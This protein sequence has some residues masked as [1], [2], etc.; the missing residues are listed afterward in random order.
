MIKF[1]TSVIGNRIEKVEVVGETECFVKLINGRKDAKRSEWQNYFNSFDEAKNY[2]ID[3]A[4]KR[5][6]SLRTQLES[7]NGA[8][9]QIK[10]IKES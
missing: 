3:N 4:Q 5:V 7:A 6:D 10:G 9:G 2:L 8:L 1:K